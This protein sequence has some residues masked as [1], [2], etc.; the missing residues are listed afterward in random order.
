MTKAG[1]GERGFGLIAAYRE[2]KDGSN[3]TSTKSPG[4][5]VWERL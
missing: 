4:G 5:F 1:V 2:S 3:I